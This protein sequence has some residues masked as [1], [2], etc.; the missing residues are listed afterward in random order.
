M[1]EAIIAEAVV[2]LA[3]LALIALILRRQTDERER[4]ARLVGE[5]R[6][7]L[8]NRIQAPDRIPLPA[9]SFEIPE[10]ED[11][12]SAAVGTI[13]YDEKYGTEDE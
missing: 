12:D 8:L 7:E 11:D 1:T 5:E 6:R 10:L 3:L 9:A 4:T 13:T 2:I